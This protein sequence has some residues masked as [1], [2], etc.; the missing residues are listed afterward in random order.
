ML[1]VF[2]AA[3]QALLYILCYRLD[4]LMA[5]SQPAH[6]LEST[7]PTGVLDGAAVHAQLRQ[8]F[9][10]TMP[11]V[12]NHRWAFCSRQGVQGVQMLVVGNVVQGRQQPA[13][14]GPVDLLYAPSV[15]KYRTSVMSVPCVWPES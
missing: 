9:A 8:L 10:D 7:S 13:I 6:G 14:G 11:Q 5:A 1:Q 2:Y 12:L 15:Q 3:C 4:H